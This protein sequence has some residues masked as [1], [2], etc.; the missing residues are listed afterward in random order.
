MCGLVAYRA[1][2]VAAVGL[3]PKAPA[4][5]GART[6]AG[7]ISVAVIAWV[8]R[9]LARTMGE[10]GRAAAQNPWDSNT[11]EWVAL[12]P[13]PHGNFGPA[14]PVVRRG[15]YEYSVPDESADWAPQTKPLS[16]RAAAAS[17]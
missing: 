6:V 17:H 16:A 3:M 7:L 11:L 15:P 12:T 1:V 8:F 10:L 4:G 2:L 9:Y 13:A 14:L 5:A